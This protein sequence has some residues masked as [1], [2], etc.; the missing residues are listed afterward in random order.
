[1][2]YAYISFLGF[3]KDLDLGV[4]ITTNGPGTNQAAVSNGEIFYYLTELVLG[5]T[6]WINTD[7]ACTFPEPWQNASAQTEGLPDRDRSVIDDNG[8]ADVRDYVGSYGN[9]LL[10]ELVVV[11]EEGN[12]LSATLNH[13]QGRLHRTDQANLVMYEATGIHRVIPA[14]DTNYLQ[15][16]F[17]NADNDGVYQAVELAENIAW[18]F[19]RG[20]QFDPLP[21]TVADPL[22]G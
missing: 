12:R 9:L 14:N 5:E 2:I 16:T 10:G 17:V 6:P 15:L 8:W 13:F 1:M 11:E 21:G 3:I 19:Q 7:T 18:T 20:V 22:I 4:F